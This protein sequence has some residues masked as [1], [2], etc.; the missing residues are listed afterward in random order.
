MEQG[1]LFLVGT[2][3]GNL[4]DITIRAVETLKSVDFVACEDTR[5]SMVLLNFYDIKKPLFSIHKFNE[6]KECEKVEKLLLEGKSVAYISDAGMPIINDPGFVLSNYIMSKGLKMEVIP[7]P[8]AL[9]TALV[10]GG[11]FE[12]KFS[13]LGFLPE[14]NVDKQKLLEPFKNLDSTLCF[15]SSSHNL[16]D[17]LNFL[18]KQ[19]GDRKVVV[20]NELTKKFEK[21]FKG[22]LSGF[23][24]ENPKGEFVVMVEGTKPTS[25]LNDLSVEQHF[26]FYINQGMSKMEAI[27]AVAKDRKLKKDEVYKHFVN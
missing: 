23:Q 15:Y 16:N 26:D 2:P 13:F 3:I 25:P 4:K 21:Y 7:G 22:T 10:G 11:I 8:T 24:I 5:H 14:K 1:T 20:A 12:D 19:L 17:D 27:K 6:K 9:T 18:F